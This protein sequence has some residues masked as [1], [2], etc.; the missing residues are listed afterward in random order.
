MVGLLNK[1]EPTREPT[2]LRYALRNPTREPTALR[3]A[4]RN[5]LFKNHTAL[6][7]ALHFHI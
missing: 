5:P 2:T 3:Y 7:C 6:R 1:G 4:L